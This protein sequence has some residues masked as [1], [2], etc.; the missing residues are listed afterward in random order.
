MMKS[1]LRLSLNVTRRGRRSAAAPR[2]S[3]S[4]GTLG[5]P[6]VTERVPQGFRQKYTGPL[7]VRR[8]V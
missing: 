2:R 8:C 4:G 1:A 7:Q 3:V 5:V 6:V